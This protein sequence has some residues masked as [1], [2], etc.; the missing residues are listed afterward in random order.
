MV[1][2][3]RVCEPHQYTRSVTGSSLSAKATA[4]VHSSANTSIKGRMR[5]M[6]NT[7]PIDFVIFI[8]VNPCKKENANIRGNLSLF[9]FI[10][11]MS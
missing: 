10:K 1:R 4:L 11:S 7:P 6:R 9:R 2:S 3:C 8:I 5:F